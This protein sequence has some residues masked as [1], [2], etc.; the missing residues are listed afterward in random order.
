MQK[1]AV[2]LWWF[3][4]ITPRADS[5]CPLRASGAHE[6]VTIHSYTLLSHEFVI[7]FRVP[8]YRAFLN[9]AD[10]RPAY[11]WQKEFLQ[12]L[13]ARGCS[14]RWVLKSPDHVFGLEALF[15]VF[16]DALVIQTHRDPLEVLQSCIRMVDGLQRTFARRE[17]IHQ[18]AAREALALAEGM[19][20]ITQFR[21]N[22]PELAERF[23]DVH[24]RELVSEPL[25]AIQRVYAQLELPL[26]SVTTRRI[27][28]LACSR[29][30]YR[31]GAPPTL[32]QLGLEPQ[33]ERLRFRNY[34]LRFGIQHS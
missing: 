32:R 22:H 21:E 23:V 17:E 10:L 33:A 15:Q 12:W 2:R 16:P 26:D 9:A 13:Q 34:C 20:R 6:C 8:S 30:R 31:Q 25:A 19:E 18:I 5:I 1:A 7:M 27:R 3:R 14:K 11:E 29:S 4:R 28:S 24:Y